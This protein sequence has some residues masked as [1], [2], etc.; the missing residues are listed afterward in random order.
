MHPA[1]EKLFE[2]RGW[3]DLDPE[4]L[5]AR[6]AGASRLQARLVAGERYAPREERRADCPVRLAA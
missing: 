6:G 4:R 1:P 5:A 3:F 2:L